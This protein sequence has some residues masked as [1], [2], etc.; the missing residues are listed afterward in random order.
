ML[1]NI[2]YFHSYETSSRRKQSDRSKRSHHRRSPT[3][4][5][6]GHRQRHRDDREDRSHSVSRRRHRERGA[7]DRSPAK[8]KIHLFNPFIK[9]CSHLIYAVL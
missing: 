6:H 2:F 5:R 3:S 8:V 9:I 1:T 7:K 4:S